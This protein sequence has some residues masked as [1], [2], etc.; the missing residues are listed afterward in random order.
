[1]QPSKGLVSGKLSHV[2]KLLKL[3]V[4][5]MKATQIRFLSE[6]ELSGYKEGWSWEVFLRDYENGYVQNL[7]R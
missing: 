4:S 5:A 2:H 7:T 1:M 6:V 3:T